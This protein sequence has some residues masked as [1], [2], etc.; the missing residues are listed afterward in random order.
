MGILKVSGAR[1]NKKQKTPVKDCVKEVLRDLLE[2]DEADDLKNMARDVPMDQENI[3]GDVPMEH[4]N[5]ARDV[6]MEQ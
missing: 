3:A 4:E 2:F 1:S 5:I 6:L